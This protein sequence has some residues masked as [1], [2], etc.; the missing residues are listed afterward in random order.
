L[1]FA[2]AGGWNK[3]FHGDLTRHRGLGFADVIVSEQ[4]LS[5][6]VANI[7]RVQINGGNIPKPA[8]SQILDELA[9][10]PPRSHHQDLAVRLNVVDN[11]RAV[12][13]SEGG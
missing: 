1:W 4:E 7:D 2:I 3:R 12:A 6:Q 8:K 10:D 9:P 5:V 11:R 13:F